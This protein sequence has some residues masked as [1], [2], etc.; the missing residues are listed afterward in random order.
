MQVKGN[1]IK[2]DERMDFYTT[3]NESVELHAT[4]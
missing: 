1:I 2:A 4:R 3:Y